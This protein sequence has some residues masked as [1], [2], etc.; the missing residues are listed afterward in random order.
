VAHRTGADRQRETLEQAVLVS[1]LG[2]HIEAG[3]AVAVA[4][5]E[6]EVATDLGEAKL[7][8]RS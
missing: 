7:Q 5:A 8:G 4:D 2:S 1:I 6:S 3:P